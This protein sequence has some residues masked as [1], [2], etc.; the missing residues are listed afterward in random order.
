[1]NFII[2]IQQRVNLIDINENKKIREETALFRKKLKEMDIEMENCDL[3]MQKLK[4]KYLKENYIKE[5]L[6]KL[7]KE[8]IK[9]RKQDEIT[10]EELDEILKIDKIKHKNRIKT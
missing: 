10:L 1:M 2:V 5:K 4:K 7:V 8:K 3:L 6:V 9:L